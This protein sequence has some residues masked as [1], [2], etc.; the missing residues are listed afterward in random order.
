MLAEPL[1][2]AVIVWA[3][4]GVGIPVY[5]TQAEE[6]GS[7]DETCHWTFTDALY[8]LI[9]TMSTV[10]YGDLS[11]ATPELKAFTV[12]MI[13]VGVVF[14]FSRIANAVTFV[15]SPVSKRGRD[16][17]ER[18]W[19]MGTLDVDKDGSS[20]V[21]VPRHP[22]IHYSKNLLPSV[23][24]M[25]VLQLVC[26][27]I[28]IRI[29][30][31][32]GFGDSIYHCFVTATTV[33]YGD[34]SIETQ[35]GRLFASLHI[36][37]SVCMLGEII[38]TADELRSERAAMLA[39]ID[40][41]TRVLDDATLTRL[42]DTA[43]D[44]RPLVE[45]D[46]LGLTELEFVLCMLVELGVTNKEQVQPYIK[47]FRSFDIDNTGRLGKEDLELLAKHSAS[48]I[49]R[50]RKV[51]GITANTKRGV[52]GVLPASIVSVIPSVVPTFNLRA[53]STVQPAA[54]QP[55]PAGDAGAQP[56]PASP[57]GTASTKPVAAASAAAG[58]A[59]TP[60]VPPAALTPAPGPLPSPPLPPVR[61]PCSLAA[62]AQ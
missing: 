43:K 39:R 23:L 27:A 40:Q 24:M 57:V 47:Q 11:P 19:P 56:T 31:S 5:M 26:A 3:Y 48:E 15:T 7:E 18:I 55:K 45:R 60:Y 6:C 14:V 22:L 37:L 28:F 52:S 49:E 59:Q 34:I 17:L 50:M 35:G 54:T 25:I 33:G 10:G 32:W 8:F 61:V 9:V 16:M 36:I 13:L 30:T 12:F 44:L 53:S 1:M 4:L 21:K 58:P 2:V 42:V 20:D 38:S 51:A 29:E 41:L 46:G 62:R